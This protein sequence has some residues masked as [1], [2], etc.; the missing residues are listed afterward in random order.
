MNGNN[1]LIWDELMIIDIAFVMDKFLEFFEKIF[2]NV[3]DGSD[4]NGEFG[5]DL[6]LIIL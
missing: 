3:I 6:E 2:F 1:V 5:E 4:L